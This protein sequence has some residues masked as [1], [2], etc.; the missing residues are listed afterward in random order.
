MHMRVRRVR[1][2][3]RRVRVRVRVRVR[4]MNGGVEEEEEERGEDSVSCLGDDV[5]LRRGEGGEGKWRFVLFSSG[6]L[7]FLVSLMSALCA[8]VRVVLCRALCVLYEVCVYSF[9]AM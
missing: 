4:K 2:R 6:R 3:V 9:A 8:C 5:T 7:S 1:V